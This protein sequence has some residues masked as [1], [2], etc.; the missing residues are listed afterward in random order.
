MKFEVTRRQVVKAIKTEPLKGRS[1]F[2][3]EEFDK[4]DFKNN[5]GCAVCAVGSILDCSL[6]KTHS[7]EELGYVARQIVKNPTLEDLNMSMDHE[8][9]VSITNGNEVPVRELIK[10]ATKVS[11]QDPLSALSSLFEGLMDREEMQTNGGMANYRAR[12]ILVNFVKRN[13]PTKLKLNTKNQY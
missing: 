8:E 3:D 11:V 6:G 4:K 13:F 12:R 1:W 2:H 5:T 10:V 9:I 7:A